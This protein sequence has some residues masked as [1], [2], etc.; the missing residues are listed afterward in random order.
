[1]ACPSWT[2]YL[3]TRLHSAAIAEHVHHAWTQFGILD[4]ECY[5]CW[6]FRLVAAP[7]DAVP[8]LDDTASTPCERILVIGLN[9]HHIV[10]LL[11]NDEMFQAPQTAGGPWWQLRANLRPH[12]L[13]T[14]AVSNIRPALSLP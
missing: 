1:M 2:V 14:V 5:P 4:V 11:L 6:H 8:S 10:H 12:Q 7:G 9:P 3:V 13:G